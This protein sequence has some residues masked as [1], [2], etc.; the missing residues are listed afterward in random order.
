MLLSS[1]L[2]AEQFGEI[3][4]L[5]SSYQRSC[6][7]ILRRDPTFINIL[8]KTSRICS[9]CRRVSGLDTRH[10]DTEKGALLSN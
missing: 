9:L 2:F 7:F 6:A 5:V 10:E 4:H 8:A 1:W 3:L